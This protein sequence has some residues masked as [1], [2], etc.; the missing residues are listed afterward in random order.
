MLCN[1][2]FESEEDR[3]KQDKIFSKNLLRLCREQVD[4]EMDKMNKIEESLNE[5]QSLKTTTEIKEENLPFEERIEP[6]EYLSEIYLETANKIYYLDTNNSGPN[7][8][9]NNRIFLQQHREPEEIM[10]EISIQVVE[11]QPEVTITKIKIE[12]YDEIEED[13]SFEEETEPLEYQPEIYSETTE[14]YHHV[15]TTDPGANEL[16]GNIMFL[17]QSMEPEEMDEINL[18]QVEQQPEETPSPI[19]TTTNPRANELDNGNTNSE[20]Q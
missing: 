4:M 20:F 17:Q 7:E 18:P 11:I 2:E 6:P 15:N 13:L 12:Q 3:E 8:F 19:D 1:L 16:E 9:E 14:N 10:Y 5:L